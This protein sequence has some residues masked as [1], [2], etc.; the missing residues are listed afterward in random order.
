MGTNAQIE[1]GNISSTLW[2]NP[3]QGYG[4][5]SPDRCSLTEILTISIVSDNAF[6]SLTE[7]RN[8]SL[9]KTKYWSRAFYG[10][11]LGEIDECAK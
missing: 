2:P 9:K 4:E 7:Y 5:G 8:R 6:P 3:I 1:I 10:N 11:G